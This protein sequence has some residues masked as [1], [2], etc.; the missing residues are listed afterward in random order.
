MWVALDLIVHICTIVRMSNNCVV[1]W[2]NTE[3]VH[4]AFAGAMY[5]QGNPLK[6]P[7][8]HIGHGIFNMHTRHTRQQYYP[9]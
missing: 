7:V 1:L 2:C 6:G 3:G 4:L 5:F 8:V 9:I